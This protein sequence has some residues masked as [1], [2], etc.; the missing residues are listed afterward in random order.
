MA[1]ETAKGNDDEAWTRL[2]KV[3]SDEASV[4]KLMHLKAKVGGEGLPLEEAY[5]DLSLVLKIVAGADRRYAEETFRVLSE[6]PL[7][8]YSLSDERKW[9]SRLLY[10]SMK[11]LKDPS[12]EFIDYLVRKMG[13][14]SVDHQL[15]RKI[16]EALAFWGTPRLAAL[17]SDCLDHLNLL[18]LARYR[19]RIEN[20][21]LLVNH[22]RESEK[23]YAEISLNHLLAGSI[24]GAGDRG[25]EPLRLP[26]ID[27]KDNTVRAEYVKLFEELL[28]NPGK[29]P[30]TVEEKTKLAELVARLKKPPSQ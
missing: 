21:R 5:P 25:R 10:E 26:P 3:L 30:L 8:E 7:Y 29:R 17:I 19:D 12:A 15:K 20:A 13:D 24:P 2:Q 14:N 22:Y 23:D 18:T 16:I 11:H 28:A 6:S 4:G 27:P 1:Q 9:R